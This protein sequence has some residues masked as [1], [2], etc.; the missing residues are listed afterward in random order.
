MTLCAGLVSSL[1]EGL[2]SLRAYSTQP[3]ITSSH[4]VARLA[5]NGSSLNLYS[6][7]IVTSEVHIIYNTLI[8]RKSLILSLVVN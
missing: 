1:T 7:T 2:D 3:M 5:L 8:P 4:R 6:E